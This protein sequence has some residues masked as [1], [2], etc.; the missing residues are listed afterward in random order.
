MVSYKCKTCRKFHDTEQTYP[1]PCG[2]VEGAGAV[3]RPRG[4]RGMTDSQLKKRKEN[5][6]KRLMT[7]WLKNVSVTI[8]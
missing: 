1:I 6:F 5:L 2:Q 8:V 4:S 7:L 3:G